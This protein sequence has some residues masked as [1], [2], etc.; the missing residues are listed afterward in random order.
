MNKKKVILGLGAVLAISAASAATVTGYYVNK[1]GAIGFESLYNGKKEITFEVVGYNN[2]KKLQITK[3]LKAVTV[4][5]LS[6]GELFFTE[7]DLELDINDSNAVGKYLREGT[8]SWVTVTDDLSMTLC[9][10][11][12]RMDKNSPNPKSIHCFDVVNVTTKDH[13]LYLP[14]L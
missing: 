2:Q 5:G 14:R 11:I 3:D 6:G 12:A 4:N 9:T 7:Y 13:T 1:A 10:K 8:T